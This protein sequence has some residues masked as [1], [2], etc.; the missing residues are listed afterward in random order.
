MKHR[1]KLKVY[2]KMNNSVSYVHPIANICF[3]NLFK[4]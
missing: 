3:L 2:E 1:K 4:L